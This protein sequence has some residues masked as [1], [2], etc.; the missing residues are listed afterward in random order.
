[1]YCKVKYWLS[2]I[3]M[4]KRCVV[5]AWLDIDFYGKKM[6]GDT[7]LETNFERKWKPIS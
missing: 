4:I 7:R 3:N 1:M 2:L 6:K 5:H